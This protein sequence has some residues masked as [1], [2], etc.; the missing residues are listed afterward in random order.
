MTE[1]VGA[2]PRQRVDSDTVNGVNVNGDP[3]TIET[4]PQ[5]QQHRF[6]AFD[7][8]LFALNHPDSSPAQAKRALEA[9]LADTDRRIQETSNLGT[10]LVQQRVNLSNRLREVASHDEGGKITAELRQKLIDIEREYNEVGRQ[11]AKTFLGPKSDSAAPDGNATFARETNVG[12]CRQD[13]K[14]MLIGFSVPQARLN[15]LVPLLTP[16]QG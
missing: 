1:F 10:A 14:T 12:L 11:S 5:P 2:L 3:F 6:S 7:T 16:P 4:P 9:H 15:W 8:Q 13:S